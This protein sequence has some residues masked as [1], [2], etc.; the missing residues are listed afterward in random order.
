MLAKR[1][2]PCLDVRDG[3]VVKGVQFRNHEIIGDIV[4]LAKRYA[5][6]GA[7][8]RCA[9]LTL[10]QP[11]ACIDAQRRTYAVGEAGIDAERFEGAFRGDRQLPAC[12]TVV[13]SDGDGEKSR[14]YAA[15]EG[16]QYK[17]FV[18]GDGITSA[19]P[20]FGTEAQSS[21]RRLF[22]HGDFD[23]TDPEAIGQWKREVGLTG[24]VRLGTCPVKSESRHVKAVVLLKSD[25]DSY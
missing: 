3:Q 10:N 6:E 5:D 17:K 7:D 14:D 24:R 8:E 13:S 12:R 9:A 23:R 15:S 21:G 25:D 20:E 16:C 1:I 11:G 4:P 2:I 19:E 22:Q 18:F